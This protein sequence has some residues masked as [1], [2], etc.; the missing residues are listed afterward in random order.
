MFAFQRV[1]A[2]HFIGTFNPLPLFGEFPCLL[3]LSVDITDFDL[4]IGFI[5]SCE[6]VPIQMW[7]HDGLFLKPS[8]MSR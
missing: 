1:N 2:R 3:V 7:F 5:R 8:L 6:S 4:E